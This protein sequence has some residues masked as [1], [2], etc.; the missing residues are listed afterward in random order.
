MG[1]RRMTTASV[2]R[3]VGC[4]PSPFSRKLRAIL[5]Y[6]RLPHVWIVGTADTVPEVAHVRP[7]LVP[8]L[9]MPDSGERSEAHTSELQSLMRISYA[10]FCLQ[11]TNNPSHNKQW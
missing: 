3:L 5:R 6:R 9:R 2:Y 10:V 8:I 1:S 4:N 7:R 11:K